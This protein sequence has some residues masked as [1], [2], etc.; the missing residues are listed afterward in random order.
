MKR[1]I[2]AAV[3]SG[4]L[5]LGGIPAAADDQPATIADDVVAQ[6]QAIAEETGVPV[7]DILGQEIPLEGDV[8]D[9]STTTLQEL[10][11]QLGDSPAGDPSYTGV[12]GTPQ[13]AAGN[14]LHAYAEAR[15]FLAPRDFVPDTS[16]YRKYDVA[17]SAY[18]PDTPAAP[19]INPLVA[20]GDPGDLPPLLA[21]HYGGR[22]KSVQFAGA[23]LL[24]V[25]SAGT[26]P[27]GSNVDTAPREPA[28]TDTLPTPV[29]VPFAHPGTVAMADTTMDYVGFALVTQGGSCSK[30]DIP[31]T[32][33]AYF[34]C[35]GA[36]L[37][38][39]DGVANFDGG[40]LDLRAEVPLLWEPA[41]AEPPYDAL[42]ALPAVPDVPEAPAGP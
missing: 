12:A 38:L 16:D 23:N 4:A 13:L 33:S 19:V 39:G 6:V 25:H 35:V 27:A 3:V 10:L 8:P 5:A 29:W 30:V 36:G 26:T 15:A 41:P 24:S 2:G 32:Q 31:F 40:P 22:L 1:I 34:V 9:G 21:V 7:E 37:L 28:D 20:A 17:E 11:A 18:S 42:P 14:V